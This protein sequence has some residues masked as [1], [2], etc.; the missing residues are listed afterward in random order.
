M[1]TYKFRIGGKIDTV[2]LGIKDF[3]QETELCYTDKEV[4]VIY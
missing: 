2:G 4:D 1:N 3:I